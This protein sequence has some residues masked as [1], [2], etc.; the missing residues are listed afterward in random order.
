MTEKRDPHPFLDFYDVDGETVWCW[1]RWSDEL[2]EELASEEFSSEE[3]AL[4]AWRD[5]KLTWSRLGDLGN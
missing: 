3:L 1:K 4:N 5:N 2:K